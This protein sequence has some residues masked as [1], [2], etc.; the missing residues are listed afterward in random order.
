MKDLDDMDLD[1]LDDEDLDRDTSNEFDAEPVSA[2]EWDSPETGGDGPTDFAT[3][4]EGEELAPDFLP[5]KPL[6]PPFAPLVLLFAVGVPVVLYFMFRPTTPE[7]VPTQITATPLPPR[8]EISPD[9]SPEP[10]PP[11]V[12]PALDES[13]AALRDWIAALSSNTH[14]ATWLA[15]EG[16]AR[17]FVVVVENIADGE[18]P[19]GHLDFLA[20]S[21]AISIV[22]AGSHAELDPSGFSRYDSVAAA[23]DSVDAGGA[24]A[25]YRNLTPLFDEAYAELGHSAGEFG[26]TLER[27]MSKLLATPRVTSPIAVRRVSVYYAFADPRLEALDPAQKQLIRMGPTN[28]VKILAKLE[29]LAAAI[30]EVPQSQP[31]DA[32]A[33][34][35]APPEPSV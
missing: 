12:L 6:V 28:Q 24:A 35:E 4:A 33:K 29:A 32:A 1:D 27:A 3:A 21:E 15:N 2:G 25:L 22:G 31:A 19:K 23:I 30:R 11:L 8:P 14:W 5:D 34:S 26:T 20:P 10:S 18:N 7:T 9:P 17:R 13:D 16:L